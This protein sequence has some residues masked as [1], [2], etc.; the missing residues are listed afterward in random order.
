CTRANGHKDPFGRELFARDPNAPFYDDCDPRDQ[1][2]TQSSDPSDQKYA[3]WYPS[4]LALPND[5]VLVVGG[6]D[7]ANS[8]GPDPDRV[9]K[10]RRNVPQ[11]DTAFTDSRVYQIGSRVYDPKTD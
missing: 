2:R 11:T 7:Q 4:A 3:R 8:V 5:T 9:A 10:G 1:Q 6:F